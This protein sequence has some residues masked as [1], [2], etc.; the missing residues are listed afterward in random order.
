MVNLGQQLWQLTIATQNMD[1]LSNEELFECYKHG[2]AL[3]YC[4][5][6]DGVSSTERRWALRLFEDV[7]IE[8]KRRHLTVISAFVSMDVE[9]N[10]ISGREE[11]KKLFSG[12]EFSEMVALAD[13][14]LCDCDNDKQRE[15]LID[16]E[17]EIVTNSC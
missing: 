6:E 17:R 1:A 12:M 11:L 9:G 2:Y 10:F 14:M 13:E 16:L 4:S 5:L 3:H 8:L 15:A 7:E